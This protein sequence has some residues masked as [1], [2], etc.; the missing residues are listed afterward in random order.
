MTGLRLRPDG[1][2]DGRQS[3]RVSA[4]V[5][6][7]SAGLSQAPPSRR[8]LAHADDRGARHALKEKNLIPASESWRILCASCPRGVAVR[9]R[10]IRRGGCGVPCWRL[11][12]LS[13]GG[14]WPGPWGTTTPP[15][16]GLRRETA[17]DAWPETDSNR[18]GGRPRSAQYR[19]TRTG[20]TRA[21]ANPLDLRGAETE[22]SPH[23][24]AARRR[25]NEEPCPRP[26]HRSAIRHWPEHPRPVR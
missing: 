14:L 2:R 6:R 22:E 18:R 12:R 9:R 25:G 15:P 26:A 5:A 19:T 3:A 1:R 23:P 16:G 24:P 7:A 17:E 8:F 21:P 4:R 10:N 11:R 13:T 20:V